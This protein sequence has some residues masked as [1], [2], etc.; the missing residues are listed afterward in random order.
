MLLTW[1][2]CVQWWKEILLFHAT[3]F[4]N[5]S[6]HQLDCGGFVVH[7]AKKLNSRKW[8]IVFFFHV[9]DR[10][11]TFRSIELD[12]QHSCEPKELEICK[13]LHFL[14]KKNHLISWRSSVL[15]KGV[16][17]QFF[18]SELAVMFDL[19]VLIPL[20]CVDATVNRNESVHFL[21]HRTCFDPALTPSQS[22]TEHTK[23][24][25]S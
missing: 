25:H 21:S 1:G 20:S 11:V 14:Q 3:Y 13:T 6:R 12:I 22:V 17:D 18:W 19:D 10:S 8:V 15:L 5:H 24:T 4:R 7:L 23:W 16:W 2:A 9:C